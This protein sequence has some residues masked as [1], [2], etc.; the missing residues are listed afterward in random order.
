MRLFVR[1]IPKAVQKDNVLNVG[2]DGF[3]SLA[4]LGSDPEDPLAYLSHQ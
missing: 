3:R 4:M 1:S 2:V